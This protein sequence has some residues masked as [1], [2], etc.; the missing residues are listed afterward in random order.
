MLK[1]EL[2][3]DVSNICVS[4]LSGEEAIDMIQKDVNENGSIS[5]KLILIDY[6][7]PGMNGP[8][9]TNLI[10]QFLYEN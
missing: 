1:Y 7:M 6:E 5:F 10:R 3:V 2:D 9:A 8:E 4:A